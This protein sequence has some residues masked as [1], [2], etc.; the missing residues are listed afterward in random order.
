[1]KY[2]L[3]LDESGY[4]GANWLDY[5]QPIFVFG[6]VLIREDLLE[7]I[8]KDF[9]NT[10]N[11]IDEFKS[12]NYFYEPRHYRFA[13]EYVLRLLEKGTIPFFLVCE[14]RFL[15][16]AKIIEYF[17]DPL[18]NNFLNN[19]LSYPNEFKKSLANIVCTHNECLTLFSDMITTN[20]FTKEALLKI[21]K[22]LSE[23]I[24][25]EHDCIKIMLKNLN[26]NSFD[27]MIEEYK[28]TTSDYPLFQ[29]YGLHLPSSAVIFHKVSS[30]FSKASSS[31]DS[32]EIICDETDNAQAIYDYFCQQSSVQIP[33]KYQNDSGS[34]SIGI[35][36]IARV[37]FTNSKDYYGL[38]IADM[39][40]GL[41]RK[42]YCKLV[43][44]KAVDKA[45]LEA[46]KIMMFIGN[47]ADSYDTTITHNLRK[48]FFE[49]IGTDYKIDPHKILKDE[50]EQFLVKF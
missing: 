34:I 19:R 15:L 46:I 10:F 28:V 26:D 35:S 29:A 22:M 9:V 30:F 44:H 40:A 16:A 5:D 23:E 11:V 12:S 4:T 8:Q 43:N 41:I 20:S 1:M 36:N 49:A 32:L 17:F 27:Q 14:K 31:E 3:Y 39:I 18:Y 21:K 50:C 48:I 25:K 38:Q 7:D 33:L 24:F 47:L 42:V 37:R 45:G 6:G 13:N 2:T